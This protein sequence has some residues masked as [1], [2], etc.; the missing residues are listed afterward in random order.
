MIESVLPKEEGREGEKKAEK[1][2]VFFDLETQKLAAEVGGWG[3]K[4][5]LKLS[6]GVTYSTAR[7]GY[8][9]YQERQ[10]EE[11]IDEMTKADLVVGFNTHNFDFAV[12]QAYYMWDLKDTLCSLDLL[13]YFEKQT[14]HLV[15]LESISQACFGLGK[16]AEGTDAVRWW[17]AGRYLD[18]AEYCCFDV[19]LTKMVYDYG[20]EHGHILYRDRQGA[21]QKVEVNW[22]IG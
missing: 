18:V 14:S 13:E 7:G 19:K 11:L 17:R 9:I 1:N 4:E 6:V 8:R 12:L 15:S 20:V 2:I 3:K 21:T 22:G 16:I 10:V 5:L